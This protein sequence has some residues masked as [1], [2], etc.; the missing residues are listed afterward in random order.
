LQV[1]CQSAGHKH[2]QIALRILALAFDFEPH[3]VLRVSP[4]PNLPA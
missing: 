2:L 4:F 1:A 3:S